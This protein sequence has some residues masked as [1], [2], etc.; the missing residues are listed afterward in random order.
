MGVLNG[1]EQRERFE[2]RVGLALVVA[3]EDSPVNRHSRRGI[4][5]RLGDGDHNRRRLVLHAA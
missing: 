2:N 4:W 3:Q 1:D 5:A